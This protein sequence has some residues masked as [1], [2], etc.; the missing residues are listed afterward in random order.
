[1]TQPI[2]PDDR[3]TDCNDTGITI[4]TE[5]RCA[6]QPVLPIS[7]D[8]GD[9]SDEYKAG[10]EAG[11]R[12]GV[13][14]MSAVAVTFTR[15]PPP[16]ALDDEVVDERDFRDRCDCGGARTRHA[17]CQRCGGDAEHTTPTSPPQGTNQSPEH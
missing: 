12:A 8:E 17:I 14:A 9:A 15:T 5:R 16:S 2:S 7:P 3:C 1:M 10:W 13:E 11:T 6:C 4:Q